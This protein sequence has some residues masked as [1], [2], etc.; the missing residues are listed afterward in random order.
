MAARPMQ[1]PSHKYELYIDIDIPED[2]QKNE[3]ARNFLKFGISRN[4]TVVFVIFFHLHF[5]CSIITQR[6]QLSLLAYQGLSLHV[7]VP[8]SGEVAALLD[9]LR[10]VNL[11]S[12]ELYFH[13][14]RRYA[15]SCGSAEPIV[16]RERML[17]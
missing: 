3:K 9:V 6:L 2:D 13:E 17:V 5:H 1:P 16:E 10:I 14:G 7:G 4:I 12:M 11:S 15:I 8:A